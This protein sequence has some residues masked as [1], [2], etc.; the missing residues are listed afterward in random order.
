MIKSLHIENFKAFKKYDIEF[1][2]LN[3][4]VG[5]NNSGKTTI[6]H[7]LQVFFWCLDQTADIGEQ[8]VTLKKTQV[9]DVSV[10]PYFNSR[11]LF[12][13]QKIRTGNA[14]TRIKI[15]VKTDFAPDISF[16]IYP[17][18][19]RNI[20]IDGGNRQLEKNQF[21]QLLAHKPIFVPGTIGIT[22]REE[23][24]RSVAQERLITEGRQNQVLRNLVY[25]LKSG[26]EW[27]QFVLTLNRL[28]HLNGLE[29]PFNEDRDEWLTATYSEND[30]TLDLVSAGSGF[31]Q[32]VN[33]LSFLYLHI[34]RVALL[35][36]PDSHLHDDLQRVTFSFLEELGVVARILK[37]GADEAL[38]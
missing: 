17:A 27:E 30:N 29:I 15:T 25:R 34:S 18:F 32:V 8:K 4:L 19:S 21:E 12:H 23:L 20:M 5:G 26:E 16:A 13:N 31:L 2:R 28:F 1:T 9:A 10:L 6:F 37:A 38:W 36:E 22:A 35:D 11:D 24:Y 3:L 33:L 14:P 7:A